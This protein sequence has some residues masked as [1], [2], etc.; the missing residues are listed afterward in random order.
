[1]AKGCWPPGV[2]HRQRAP[3]CWLPTLLLGC[4]GARDCRRVDRVQY[5]LEPG[6]EQFKEFRQLIL[7]GAQAPVAYF[8]YP[9]KSSFFTSPECTIHTLAKP[10]EDYVGALEALAAALSVRGEDRTVEQA[11]RPTMPSGEI[12]LAGVAAA[13]GASAAG[14][15]HCGRRVDDLGPGI[16]GSDEWSASA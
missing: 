13:V 7:V 5:V 2:S 14:T 4:S 3:D 1:M 9:G 6:I 16:D 12:T 15:L 8:A 10:G 11:E